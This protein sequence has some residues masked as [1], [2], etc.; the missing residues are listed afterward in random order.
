MDTSEKSPEERLIEWAN[1][2]L[3]EKQKMLLKEDFTFIADKDLDKGNICFRICRYIDENNIDIKRCFSFSII[4]RSNAKEEHEKYFYNAG[5][6]VYTAI[7]N[8][9][10]DEEYKFLE[11]FPLFC[12]SSNIVDSIN[13]GIDLGIIKKGDILKLVITNWRK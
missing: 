5:S 13:K 11:W 6:S 3:T 2:L 12:L 10:M 1:S 7:Y 8:L 4:N 9:S